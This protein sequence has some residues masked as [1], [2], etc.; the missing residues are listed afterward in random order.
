MKTKTLTTDEKGKLAAL[1]EHLAEEI[2]EAWASMCLSMEQFKRRHYLRLGELFI[3]LRRTFAKDRKG[4]QAF[5][6]F[7]RQRCPAIKRESRDEY[8]AYRKR[9]GPVSATSVAHLPPLRRVTEPHVNDVNRP[10]DQ[11]RRI[12]DEEVKETARFE[13]QRENEF[14][15]IRELAFKI[16]NIGFRALSVKMHPD[17]DGGSN[18]SMRRLNQAKKL[19][20]DGLIRAVARAI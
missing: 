4:D 10:R 3:K 13:V 20:S 1:R 14:E 5:S 8:M 9:L 11:Y 19:L 2:G 17:K 6:A 16:I 18:V 12:V 7:V 15:I